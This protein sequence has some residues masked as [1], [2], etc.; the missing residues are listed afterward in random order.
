MSNFLTKSTR[1]EEAL[2]NKVRSV[3]HHPEARTLK[4]SM[5]IVVQGQIYI[6]CIVGIIF[7]PTFE[8]HI[9]LAYLGYQIGNGLGIP[10]HM[11]HNTNK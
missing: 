5:K 4:G 6:L 8:E 10:S 9:F 11:I 2:K 7:R 1:I 3:Q